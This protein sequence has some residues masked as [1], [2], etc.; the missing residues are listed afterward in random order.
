MF[1]CH[2]L[3]CSI[4]TLITLRSM[5]PPIMRFILSTDPLDSAPNK[6]LDHL[7]RSTLWLLYK[8]KTPKVLNSMKRVYFLKKSKNAKENQLP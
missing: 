2:I 1:L 5:L 3:S 8:R 7:H 4:P 6:T